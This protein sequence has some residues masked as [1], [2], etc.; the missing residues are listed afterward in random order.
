MWK[1]RKLW[2]FMLSDSNP[3][4]FPSLDFFFSPCQVCWC[5][6]RLR[7]HRL[8]THFPTVIISIAMK[9]IIKVPIKCILTF[10]KSN[11]R[12]WIVWRWFYLYIINYTQFLPQ[13]FTSSFLVRKSSCHKSWL[14]SK[15]SASALCFLK[16]SRNNSAPIP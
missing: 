14:T 12:E 6:A 4:C 3:S 9:N 2:M 10:W 8:R 15:G 11:K 5:S 1:G 16:L 13:R 7:N